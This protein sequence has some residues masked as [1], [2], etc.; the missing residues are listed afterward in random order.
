MAAINSREKG[1]GNERENCKYFTKWW[2]KPRCEFQRTDAFQTLDRSKRMVFGDII[3]ILLDRNDFD[4][5][6]PFSI[7]LKKE[8]GWCLTH[9]LKANPASCFSAWWKQ[10]TED[11]RRWSKAPLLVFGKNYTGHFAVYRLSDLNK[12]L[13]KSLVLSNVE[14][15]QGFTAIIN[16]DSVRILPLNDFF[17]RFTPA[18]LVVNAEATKG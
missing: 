15:N 6:F 1:K 4:R 9:L 10:C 18:H 8:E 17:R 13:G 14:H 3:P 2:K 7:E 12:E 16:S 5:E 11:A